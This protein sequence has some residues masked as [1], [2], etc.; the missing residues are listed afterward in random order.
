MKRGNRSDGGASERK[1]QADKS[2]LTAK[3]LWEEQMTSGGEW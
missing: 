3:Q 2:G 1:R